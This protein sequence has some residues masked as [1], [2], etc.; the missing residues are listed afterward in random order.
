LSTFAPRLPMIRPGRAAQR[1][2]RIFSPM[3]SMSMRAMPAKAYSLRTNLRI[4]KSS[5]SQ[6]P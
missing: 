2:I 1:L 5:T 3:R 4:L 6:S